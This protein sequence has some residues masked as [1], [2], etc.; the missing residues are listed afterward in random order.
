M[1]AVMRLSS[2]YSNALM[3]GKTKGGKFIKRPSWQL[4]QQCAYA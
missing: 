3:P 2:G 4:L 1:T